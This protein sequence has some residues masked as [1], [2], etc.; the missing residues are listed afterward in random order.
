M[1]A[2]VFIIIAVISM[3]IC[4]IVILII[5]ILSIKI[6]ISTNNVSFICF[7]GIVA[8][9]SRSTCMRCN[10]YTNFGCYIFVCYYCHSIDIPDYNINLFIVEQGEGT[11]KG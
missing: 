7:T 10:L 3:Y 5:S 6:V 8:Y 1:C 11:P 2:T 4:I 9:D